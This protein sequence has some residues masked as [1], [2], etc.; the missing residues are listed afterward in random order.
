MRAEH[1]HGG[2]GAHAPAFVCRAQGVGRIFND[3]DTVVL[4]NVM[5]SVHVGGLAGE[6]DDHDGL[7]VGG[8]GRFDAARVQV[9]GFG[10]HIG[11]DRSRAAVQGAVGA[12]GETE[13]RCDDLVAWACA[14]GRYGG[15]QRG[16]ARCNRHRVLCPDVIGHGLLI[17]GDIRPG[18]QPI[19]AQHL[20]N[21]FDV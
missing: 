10:L 11:K 1:G 2:E 16:R 21:R 3:H 15:M 14:D 7:G 4:G 19:T 13:R 17:G 9:A 12:R 20:D 18:C 8:D 5:D 6:M